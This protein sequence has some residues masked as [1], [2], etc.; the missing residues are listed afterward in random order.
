MISAVRI[1]SENRLRDILTDFSLDKIGRDQSVQEV[2][3]DVL[4]KLKPSFADADPGIVG[5]AFNRFYKELFRTLI[6]QQQVR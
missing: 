1:L 4:D 5:E 2:R 3:T 6:L